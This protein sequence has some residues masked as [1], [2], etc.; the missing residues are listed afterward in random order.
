MPEL[1]FKL[2]KF[3]RRPDLIDDFVYDSAKHALSARSLGCKPEPDEIVVDLVV[4]A[5]TRC[6]LS[7]SIA[8]ARRLLDAAD[9]IIAETGGPKRWM[10]EHRLLFIRHLQSFCDVCSAGK[11]FDDAFRK[12]RRQL[13]GGWPQC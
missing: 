4:R 1:H 6:A 9:A 5:A 2:S 3:L 7:S 10:S 11:T 13:Y 12:V 8:L